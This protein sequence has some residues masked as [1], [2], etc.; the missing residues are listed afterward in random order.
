MNSEDINLQNTELRHG[1]YDTRSKEYILKMIKEAIVLAGGLGT[2][3]REVIKDVP[4]PMADI[5]GKPFLEYVLRLL[6]K[7]SIEK[8]VL[9]VGYRYEFIM[10][11]FG[12]K[13]SNI[14]LIY[15]IEDEPLGTGGAIK[16]AIRLIDEDEIFIFNGDTFFQ[17]DLF[18]FYEF[19]SSKT[20]RLSI[21]LKMVNI[22]DRYGIVKIDKNN[23]ITAFLEKKEKQDGLINGGIYLM[24][25]DF[26]LSFN[27]P[28]KFSFEQDFLE[29]YYKDYEFYGFPFDSYFI[30]IGVPEDYDK[31][32][33]QWNQIVF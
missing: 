29:K 10:D 9:S 27:L 3:L 12:D 19:H 21:A 24:N 15:S 22:T 14:R 11:Y 4:K 30:D 6:D 7:Q 33:Y 1:K 28:D 23:R 5:N 2:R 25:K 18:K 32:K 13:F 17:V 20:S 16:K 8:V 31:A 26:F